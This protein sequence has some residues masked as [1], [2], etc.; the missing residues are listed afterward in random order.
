MQLTTAVHQPAQENPPRETQLVPESEEADQKHA[1]AESFFCVF[2]LL[3]AGQQGGFMPPKRYPACMKP[4]GH[5]G[6]RS[7]SE[8]RSI[9]SNSFPQSAQRYSYKGIGLFLFHSYQDEIVISN[10][11]VFHYAFLLII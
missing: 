9:I 3:Q 1:T 6:R 5:S 10:K 7:A 4:A 2:G 11:K 8:K